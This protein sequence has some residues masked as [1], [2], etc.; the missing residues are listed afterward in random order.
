MLPQYAA[1]FMPPR[2]NAGLSGKSCGAR[3]LTPPCEGCH[4]TNALRREPQTLDNTESSSRSGPHAVSCRPHSPKRRGGRRGSPLGAAIAGSK[5]SPPAPTWTAASSEG[6]SRRAQIV[7]PHHPDGVSSN[8]ANR[9]TQRPR[10]GNLWPCCWI[11]NRQAKNRHVMSQVW[12]RERLSVSDISFV[13][14]QPSAPKNLLCKTES[15]DQNR[16]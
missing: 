4:N 13:A 11:S 5:A 15:Q 2:L 14:G 1:C 9:P 16:S 6:G 8:G 10:A 3:N 12:A 7:P